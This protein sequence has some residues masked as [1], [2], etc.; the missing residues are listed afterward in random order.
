MTPTSGTVARLVFQMPW[1]VVL[2]LRRGSLVHCELSCRWNSVNDPVSARVVPEKRASVAKS[3]PDRFSDRRRK[4]QR[5]ACDQR[6]GTTVSAISRTRHDG[7]DSC[8]ASK[9]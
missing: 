4:Q 9:V 8:L 2:A 6:A 7:S 3:R 1:R 5:F